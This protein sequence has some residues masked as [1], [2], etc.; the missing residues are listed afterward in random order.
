MGR[1]AEVD[2]ITD[3][4]IMSLKS[5]LEIISDDSEILSNIQNFQFLFLVFP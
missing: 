2:E 4:P 1:V 5:G 3:F